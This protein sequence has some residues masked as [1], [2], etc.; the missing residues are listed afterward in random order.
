MR[1]SKS[2]FFCNTSEVSP[3]DPPSFSTLAGQASKTNRWIIPPALAKGVGLSDYH[4]LGTHLRYDICNPGP[5]V[6]PLS[7]SLP[8][9]SSPSVLRSSPDIQPLFSHW[10]IEPALFPPPPF[11]VALWEERWNIL[12]ALPRSRIEANYR[13]AHLLRERNKLTPKLKL[14]LAICLSCDPGHQRNFESDVNIS[15]SR[16]RWATL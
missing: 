6:L 16:S 15:L 3:T 4:C 7:P 9:L 5:S 2:K 10:M 1:F 11:C 14:R 8:K 12:R 13:V